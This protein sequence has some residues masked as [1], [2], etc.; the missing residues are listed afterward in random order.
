MR[1]DFACPLQM[2]S[3]PLIHSLPMV[4]KREPAMGIRMAGVM[5]DRPLEHPNRLIDPIHPKQARA[6]IS[7]D[8]ERIRVTLEHGFEFVHCFIQLVT[9]EVHA[10]ELGPQ[11]ERIAQPF[12][13]A[14]QC[15][16]CF[17]ISL[18]LGEDDPET[19]LS[20]RIVGLRTNRH[21]VVRPRIL[22]QAAD[23]AE[24]PERIPC[25]RRLT[26]WAERLPKS[27]QHLIEH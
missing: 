5:G 22:S 1:V 12:L 16:R 13:C 27:S 14:L 9:I 18:E 15:N 19:K 10:P 24:N 3:R 7:E 26:Q 21:L 20:L 4:R 23:R 11:A 17:S 6:E 8:E 25:G 2:I